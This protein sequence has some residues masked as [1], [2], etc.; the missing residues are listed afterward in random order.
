MLSNLDE[1]LIKPNDVNSILEGDLLQELFDFMNKSTEI[2]SKRKQLTEI[3]IKL[4][5][6]F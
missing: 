3:I 6:I 2:S 4:S 1:F 5:L